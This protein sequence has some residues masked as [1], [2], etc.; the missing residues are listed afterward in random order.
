MLDGLA[1][2]TK[3]APWALSPELTAAPGLW[4]GCVA[5]VPLW[6]GQSVPLDYVSGRSLRAFDA[7]PEWLASNRG[8]AT[9][10]RGS[11][12]MWLLDSN[13]VL[14]AVGDRMTQVVVVS[15]IQSTG[16]IQYIC[17]KNYGGNGVKWFSIGV[18]NLATLPVY[19]VDN[20]S[21][22][23]LSNGSTNIMG[24][25]LHVVG[26]D[27]DI[28]GG[29]R[30]YVDGRQDAEGGARDIANGGPVVLGGR[31]D[32]DGGRRYNGFIH[33]YALWSRLLTDDEHFALAADPFAMLRPAEGPPV[34]AFFDLGAVK[35]ISGA[36]SATSSAA[37]AL[38]RR[39]AVSG[40][41][42]A[43]SSLTGAASRRRG[44][45]GAADAST[46]VAGALARRR[47]VSGGLSAVSAVSGAV[48]RVRGVSGS[49]AAVSALS[50]VASRVRGVSGSLAATTALTGSLSEAAEFDPYH[51]GTG[52][53][54]GPRAVS[55]LWRGPRQ[56]KGYWR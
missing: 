52:Y 56:G 40:A 43:Q 24:G 45:S 44:V 12:K 22:L 37:G 1:S 47:G 51:V 31:A 15:G 2:H 11:T 36:L 21:V 41:A 35:N 49:L 33:F 55:G 16:S 54:R 18:D 5:A 26:Q 7:Q 50:G 39:R 29:S 27:N 9:D 6:E 10:H 3:P 53:W 28:A 13:A 48:S 38:S 4:R 20:G 8:K 46:D 42:A 30:G 23:S 32:G 25:S 17:G 34:A 14:D 19:Y